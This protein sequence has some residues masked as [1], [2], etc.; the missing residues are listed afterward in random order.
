MKN[1]EIRR[2]Y[3]YDTGVNAFY[4]LIAT[5]LELIMEFQ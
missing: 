3:L 1:T 2:W 5:T 4:I